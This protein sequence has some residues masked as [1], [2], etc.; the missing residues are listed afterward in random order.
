MA[1]DGIALPALPV[2]YTENTTPITPKMLHAQKRLMFASVLMNVHN[3][4]TPLILPQLLYS[5]GSL[6]WQAHV[7]NGGVPCCGRKQEAY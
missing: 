2:D 3:H 7:P 6:N 5:N 4:S 1:A